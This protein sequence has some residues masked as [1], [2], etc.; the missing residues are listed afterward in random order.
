VGPDIV[1]RSQPN[2]PP[3]YVHRR[4]GRLA[5]PVNGL[6]SGCSPAGPRPGCTPAGI[7]RRAR[8]DPGH[9]ARTPPAA[10][11]HEPG[12]RR[13][14]KAGRPSS[15][16]RRRRRQDCGRRQPGRM[17]RSVGHQTWLMMACQ[18]A[19]RKQFVT[20]GASSAGSPAS[21]W[22]RPWPPAPLLRRNPVTS[23]HDRNTVSIVPGVGVIAATSPRCRA[24]R[25]S[26]LAAGSD[27]D[28]GRPAGFSGRPARDRRMNP[29]FINRK[30]VPGPPLAARRQKRR[31]ELRCRPPSPWNRAAIQPGPAIRPT[32]S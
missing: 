31:S 22:P 24:G 28:T 3:V 7:R 27:K 21:S 23:P 16:L 12:A 5:A 6:V 1:G 19:G 9:W 13:T 18:P 30:I 32:E 11:L 4:S 14:A 8:S 10:R 17:V 2:D 25:K 15:G 26:C 20:N 29:G